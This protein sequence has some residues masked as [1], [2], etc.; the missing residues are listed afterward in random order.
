[1]LRVRHRRL[2]IL[3]LS[4]VTLVSWTLM[5]CGD[6]ADSRPDRVVLVTIDT[7]R[8][9]HVG[10]YGYPLDITP[11]IDSL[12]KSGVV[13]DRALAH[14]SATAPSHASM[15]TGLYPIQHGVNANGLKLWE[16]FRTVA[17]AFSEVGYRTAA[18]VSTNAH[19]K[20]GGLDQGFEIYDEQP[21]ADTSNKKKKAPYRPAVKT[22]DAAVE[23]LHGIAREDK[24]FAWIHLYDPHKRLRPPPENLA[25]VKRLA[26]E[27]GPDTHRE[28]LRGAH[29]NLDFRGL[30]RRI[31]QY[32]AEILYADQ[33]VERLYREMEST[34]S[35][36]LW[37][38]TSDH[39]QGLY[40]H[41]RWFGHSKQV[42][43]TQILVPLIFHSTR[44]S[45]APARFDNALVQHIDLVPTLIEL[46]DLDFP[47]SGSP[48]QGRSLVPYLKGTTPEKITPFSF[49]QSSRDLGR[50]LRRPE[51]SWPKYSLQNLEFKYILN[52]RWEDEFYDLRR[53]PNERHNRLGSDELSEEEARILGTLV[54][55]MET[56]MATER[57]AEM[58][59]EDTLERLKALGYLQ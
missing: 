11:F 16:G 28:A 53:D 33:Q 13:F 3:M 50:H 35:D 4:T 48:M 1:M 41:D 29:G 47:Q 30:Y 8:A 54:R 37:I 42:Y 31:L 39:G 18:F 27:L 7:L 55:M 56:L 12:A 45:F 59:D 9:D 5:G 57:E 43:N 52:E 14:A 20:W 26:K 6:A 38:V 36:D 46:F 15:F 10:A 34:D 49:A 58:V 19:F 32:D 22:I 25:Q 44:A 24:V 2:S 40:S 17:E 51:R 21:L 23:W